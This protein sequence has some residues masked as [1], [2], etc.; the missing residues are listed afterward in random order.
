MKCKK[1]SPLNHHHPHF[2]HNKTNKISLLL[3]FLF[4]ILK[5]MKIKT[6][7]TTE[8]NDN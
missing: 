4:L 8:R 1:I 2:H 3:C 6:T 5:D 7:N